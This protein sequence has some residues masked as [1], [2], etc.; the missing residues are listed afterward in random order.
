MSKSVV[1]V[2]H[3]K[4]EARL[5][6]AVSQFEAEL[7]DEHKASFR[8]SRSKAI[9]SPPGIQDVM[10]LTAEIDH[11]AEKRRRCLGPR[12]TN[13][14]QATQQFAALG[15]VL[16]GGSQ[17]I[18]VCGVW[19]T[20]RLSLQ[21]IAGFTSYLER[22]SNVFMIA[23]RLAPR[24][25]KMA[26]LYPRS[27]ELQTSLC[28][29]FIVIV[30]LCREIST[31]ARKSAFGKLAASLS[32]PN[33]KSYQSDLESW[34]QMIK[35]EVTYLM[36][37]RL[38]D[39]GDLN[40][41]F[42][43]MSTKLHKSSAY[44]QLVQ[45]KQ[46][47]LD[48][49][50]QYDH[51]VAW[52]QI[53]KTG[54]TSL[55][56]ESHVYRNWKASPL[57]STVYWQ[58]RLWEVRSDGEHM[59][60]SLARQLLQSMTDF[61]AATEFLNQNMTD[62]IPE[63]LIKLL[64][65]SVDFHK[66]DC[67]LVVDGLDE[68][69]D[70]Q[71]HVVMNFLQQLQS[72]KVTFLLCLSLR[73]YPK[74]AISDLENRIESGK[75]TIGNPTLILEIQDALL[76]GSEGMFLWVA[77][78]IESICS[79]ESDEEIRHALTDLP[80]DL[81][82]TFAR[83]FKSKSESTHQRDIFAMLVV[84]KR[85][86]VVQELREALSVVPG[87]LDWKPDRLLNNIWSTLISCGSLIMVDEEQ[88]TV[89]LVHSSVRRFLLEEFEEFKE[90]IKPL[91]NLDNA[92]R[93]VTEIIITYLNYSVFERQ[94]VAETAHQ[95]HDHDQIFYFY[96]YAT[97]YLPAHVVKAQ[98]LGEEMQSLFARLLGPG[99]A[100]KREMTN[101]DNDILL[102]W[103]AMKGYLPLVAALSRPG[104]DNSAVGMKALRQAIEVGES[105]MVQW[106]LDS[107]DGFIPSSLPSM[108]HFWKPI[109]LAVRC[110]SLSTIQSLL[111]SGKFNV[112]ERDSSTGGRTPLHEAAVKGLN[113]TAALLRH[114]AAEHLRDDAGH[115]ALHLA[116]MHGHQDIVKYMITY[117][118]SD[119]NKTDKQGLTSLHLA[120]VHGNTEV[121]RVLLDHP[122]TDASI[123]DHR[124]RSAGD[125]ALENTSLSFVAQLDSRLVATVNAAVRFR[126]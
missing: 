103:A 81:S 32:D 46:R 116:A 36:A 57:A 50:S 38:E 68:L 40:S 17:N 113:E 117:Q 119:P 51:T 99:S 19:T 58:A 11:A 120:A 71:R 85:P 64:C 92:H 88:L 48:F 30:R 9:G 100:L 70:D 59:I 20:V 76:K 62:P 84:A 56:R 39:E 126:R 96:D 41:R 24:H 42:R 94:V 37:K 93:M 121:V 123:L 97:S 108:P 26:L 8:V 112:N 73:E 6:Q 35:D 78:Q 63:R 7:S 1:I 106:L 23:G 101:E 82:Q 80:K 43:I 104:Q 52:K 49:C 5:A 16:V 28:E 47:V 77:L 86:L 66:T 44:Q 53:R 25:E 83:A 105:S 114:S 79:M 102:D 29:Y 110:G 109:H 27:S 61:T 4:P 74:K 3:L 122:S 34:G 60:G 90:P 124:G 10:Q 98:D 69:D 33:L 89:H 31:F 67:Y 65:G 87:D 107:K 55:F 75:L 22:L 2:S 14:L 54:N 115:T 91:V 72:G 12:L 95:G 111:A 45:I 21:I 118:S 125:L 13:I 15:D 18:L